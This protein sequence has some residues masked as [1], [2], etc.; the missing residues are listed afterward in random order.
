MDGNV[1]FVEMNQNNMMLITNME[2][3]LQI[4][5]VC[6]NVPVA[7]KQRLCVHVN[8]ILKNSRRR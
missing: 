8:K 6:Q 5:T 2:S 4:D 3:Q 1:P 7:I